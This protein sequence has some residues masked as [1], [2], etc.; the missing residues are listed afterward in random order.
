MLGIGLVLVAASIGLAIWAVLSQAEEK[1]TVRASLRQLEG[2]QVENVRDQG[3]SSRSASERCAPI[4]SGLTGLDRRFTPVGYVDQVK[5][6]HAALG[7][8]GP[9]SIDRFLAIRVVSRRAHPGVFHPVLLRPAA[10][11]DA[12]DRRVPAGL[13]AP[14]ARSG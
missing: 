5:R 14:G 9:E 8:S 10:A 6:K 1:A 13:G 4:L 2:Y 7:I 12:E 3:C 11:G